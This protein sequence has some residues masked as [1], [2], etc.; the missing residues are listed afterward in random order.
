M[1]R[2]LATACL[3]AA[4]AAASAARSQEAS[5]PVPADKPAA[6]PSAPAAG[7][8]EA[9]TVEMKAQDGSSRGTVK[10][11][12]TPNGLLLEANLSGFGKGTGDRIHGFHFHQT[13]KCEGNFESAG[14]HYNPTNKEHGYLS[15]NGPH[16]GDMPNFVL[17][18]DGTARFAVF[19]PMVRMTGGEAPLNDTDGTVIMIHGM[20]DD[21]KSAPAGMAGERVAC[22]VVFKAS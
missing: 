4:I 8:G 13:G 21:Y 20:A 11:T 1:R 15:A 14:G 2:L 3:T 9:V 19:N 17:A 22:G 5:P 6:A 7:M 18:D 12:P 10:I 16:A